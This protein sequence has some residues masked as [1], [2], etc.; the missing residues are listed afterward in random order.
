MKK[1]SILIPTYN[2]EENVQPLFEA[3]SNL[4]LN[5]LPQY[6]Y[7]VIYIDNDSK[8]KTRQIIRNMAGNNERVKAIFNLR[9]FGQ[10]N[11]PYYGIMQTSGDCTILMCADFQDPVEMIPRFVK[12]WENGH[13][14]VCAIKTRSK[15][16]PV[17]YFL[18]KCYYKTIKKLSD[19]EQIENF[20]GFGLYD[21]SFIE[22]MKELKDATPFLRG[23]VAEYAPDRKEIPYC[24][25]KRKFGISKNNW[26]SLY[27]TAMLSFTSYTKIMLR[28]AVFIGALVG[29]SSFLISIVYLIFKLIYWDRFQAGTAPII[30]SICFLGAV[31][32]FFLGILGE[33]IL[34]MNTRIINRP[35]I[36]ESERINFEEKDG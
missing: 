31:Q 36:I 14:V 24:Q 28:L 29:G 13:K 1:I 32:L 25:E 22:I 8:D 4:F 15:T 17:V 26:Y 12:E 5:E 34:A 2:E 7:E 27:E 6:E 23:I 19:I 3:I 35:L 16:N 10:H 9:N 20:T 21:K 30:I 11:S 33:Y 18:R